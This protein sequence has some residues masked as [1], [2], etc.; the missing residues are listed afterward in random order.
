M[1][2]LLKISGE[3]LMGK[4]EFGASHEALSNIAK[5]IAPLQKKG[6]EIGIVIG[7]GNIFRGLSVAASLGLER[8][9]ADQM[10]ML[11]TLMNG[12]LLTQALKCEGVETILMSALECPLVAESY[13]WKKAIQFLEEKKLVLFVGGTGQPYFTTDTAAA[14][15]ACEIKAELLLKATTRVDGIY[16]KDPLKNQDAKKFNEI[17][18]AEY[19]EKKLGVMDLTAITLCMT[20]KIPIRV[21]NLY[22][23]PLLEVLEKSSFGSLI[24]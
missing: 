2:I 8:T 14:L 23:S 24:R 13:N 3:A 6:H 11:A 4:Q 9:P 7:G 18:Y 10:G 1:R 17:S 21:F 5:M 19:V 12:I 22:Q 15:R 20:N 16:D